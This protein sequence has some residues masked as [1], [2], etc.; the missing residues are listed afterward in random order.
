NWQVSG[1]AL[2]ATLVT[3]DGN[4]GYPSP[5]RLIDL[6]DAE[7]IATF[8]TSAKFIDACLK[9]GLK[10]RETHDLSSLRTILSTGSPHI[11]QS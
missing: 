11:P 1:L 6:I 5:A 4:P 7:R 2:G 3:Y 9:A 8:G 10:P